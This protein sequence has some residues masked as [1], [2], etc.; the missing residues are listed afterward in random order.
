MC[1]WPKKGI[2]W[3]CGNEQVPIHRQVCKNNTRVNVPLMVHETSRIRHE[4]R[5]GPECRLCGAAKATG[6]IWAFT[7]I[8]WENYLSWE[9]IWF[10]RLEKKKILLCWEKLIGAKNRSRETSLDAGTVT[11]KRRLGQHVSQWGGRPGRS[12]RAFWRW[13]YN[14]SRCEREESRVILKFWGLSNSKNG[15]AIIE[16]RRK[17][18]LNILSL[19]CL[20]SP[21][22][23]TFPV[24]TGYL[25]A[26]GERCGLKR[27]FGNH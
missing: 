15:I 23:A 11:Y 8:R 13:S 5:K 14:G 26:P 25:Q 7:R 27:L 3:E 19:T 20:L 17:A 10:S 18:F 22:G 12:Q 1:F 6:G 9:V 4:V 2:G 21:R 24:S 16:I